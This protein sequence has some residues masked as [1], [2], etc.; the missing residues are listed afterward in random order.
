MAEYIPFQLLEELKKR[1]AVYSHADTLDAPWAVR[2]GDNLR[3]AALLPVCQRA[4]QWL[5]LQMCLFCEYD[6]NKLW[7]HLAAYA[8]D[9]LSTDCVQCA[10]RLVTGQNFNAA[11]KVAELVVEAETFGVRVT[12]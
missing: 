11:K 7:Q 12:P 9:V 8:H 1:G 2:S 3:A 5:V 4:S 6:G 10:G